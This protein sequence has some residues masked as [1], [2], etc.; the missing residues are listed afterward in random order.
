MERVR[1][2][3]AALSLVTAIG[4]SAPFAAAQ[5]RQIKGPSKDAQQQNRMWHFIVSA[6]DLIGSPVYDSKGEKAGQIEYLMIG[7]DNGAVRYVVISSGGFLDIGDELRALPWSAF[8]TPVSRTGARLDVTRK[9]LQESYKTDQESLSDL[10]KPTVIAQ[11][12]EY[13]APLVDEQGGE[14]KTGSKS[15]AAATK[16]QKQQE[17][18]GGDGAEAKAKSSTG[19]AAK[20]DS[21]TQ[22]AKKDEAGV[23]HILVGRGLITTV[24][25][26]AVQKS[27]EL[28]GAEVRSADGKEVGE[29]DHLMIETSVG[30]V[31]YVLISRGGFLGAGGEWVPVPFELLSQSPAS[32]TLS[33][34]V[35]ASELQKIKALPKT[36]QPRSVRRSDLA[37][38]YQQY[39]VEPFWSKNEQ[40]DNQMNK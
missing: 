21:K 36:E 19:S 33:L 5:D 7:R 25:A 20:S 14:K 15:K 35:N 12:T 37:K 11:V 29:I 16:E 22:P 40:K 27:K 34:K 32:E 26:P 6:W 1:V 4:M 17:Q 10:T 13:W 30:R 24:V 18:K 39:K 8:D 9:A 38:L 3:S 31:A 28:V 2:L 23:P